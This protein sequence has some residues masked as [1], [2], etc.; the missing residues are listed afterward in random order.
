M[1]PMATFM[2][3]TLPSGPTASASSE[4]SGQSCRAFLPWDHVPLAGRAWGEGLFS[5]ASVC[6]P[7]HIHPSIRPSVC[8]L[9]PLVN[10]G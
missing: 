5:R 10:Q 4:F 6:L 9:P 8:P 2:G 7:D 3:P 1:W